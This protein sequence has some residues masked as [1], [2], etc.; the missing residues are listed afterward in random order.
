MSKITV[1]SLASAI[2][3]FAMLTAAQAGPRYV[4]GDGTY[5]VASWWDGPRRPPAACACVRG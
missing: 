1:S 4:Q 5:Q 2:A 3:M